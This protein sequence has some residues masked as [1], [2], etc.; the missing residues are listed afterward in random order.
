[1]I[2]RRLSAGKSVDEVA[3]RDGASAGRFDRVQPLPI[4][5]AARAIDGTKTA[6]AK[7]ALWIMAFMAG[8]FQ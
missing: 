8:S 7:N 3:R 1:M 5:F 4:I 2:T 6:A